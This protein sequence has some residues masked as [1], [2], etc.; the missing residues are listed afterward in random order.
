MITALVNGKIRPA[1][2]VSA[3]DSLIALKKKHG[4]NFWPVVEK[5]VDIWGHG[6]PTREAHII[7]MK[8]LRESR[9]NTKVFNKRF[10]G[11][12][13]DKVTGGYLTYLL[14][15]PSK[16]INGLRALYTPQELVFDKKFYHAFARRFPFFLVADKKRVDKG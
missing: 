8:D 3:A 11:V 4:S 9:K 16:I 15:I 10:R 6:K 1:G 7:R 2:A 13:K 14:D 12:S 5:M